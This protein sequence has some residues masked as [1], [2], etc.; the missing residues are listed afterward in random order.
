MINPTPK[1]PTRFN[2]GFGRNDLPVTWDFYEQFFFGP[3]GGT[4]DQVM[5]TINLALRF[6][7][8]GK[9]SAI[10]ED[11]RNAAPNEPVLIATDPPYFD[12]IGYADLSDYFYIWHRR[13]LRKVFP[14]LYGTAAVPKVGELTALQPHH[15][16]DS[17]MARTY[18]ID[19]FTEVFNSL[20]SAMND[21][22]P[23]I[24]VYASKEQKA[25]K[26]EETRWAAILT[27]LNLSIFVPLFIHQSDKVL[28]FIWNEIWL[29]LFISIMSLV[30]YIVYQY[31]FNKIYSLLISQ[32]VFIICVSLA[33]DMV[34]H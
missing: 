26:G 32:F 16:G 34:L 27:S 18:F 13:S 4:W 30:Y 17:E 3:A 6:A 33:Y 29:A 22:L 7:P 9:G 11:A 10:R 19:G 5:Q 25:G 12:A 20:K 15:S 8:N 1:G 2:S 24:I 14:D 21:S 28:N 23:M 31:S